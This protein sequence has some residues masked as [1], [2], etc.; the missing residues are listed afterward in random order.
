M[1]RN[2]ALKGSLDQPILLWSRTTANAE[3]H[4]AE[5]G[6]ERSTVASSL[7]E[8]VK[9]ADMIWSCLTDLAAV[10]Q[11]FDTILQTDVKGKLFVECSTVTPEA[12]DAL[13]AKVLAA[14][15]EFVTMP[16]R[17]GSL[18]GWFNAYHAQFSASPAWLRVVSSHACRPASVN[19]LTRSSLI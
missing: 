16:G 15:A 13:A 12:S 18:L 19:P 6:P 1:S 14:G 11:T 8:A 10:S 17:F 5:L 9:G 3:A 7:T 2:L 4:A